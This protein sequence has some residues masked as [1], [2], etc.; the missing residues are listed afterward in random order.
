MTHFAVIDLG[1]NSVR[2]SVW[3]V[4]ADG[5]PVAETK[6][7]EMVRLSED[8]GD[9]MT[10]KEPAIARTIAALQKF[11]AIYSPLEDL[12][13]KAYAT[14]ATRQ[15]KNQKKFL[16]RVQD[17]VGLQIEVIPGVR[18]AELD[19]VGVINTLNVQSGLI[20]DTGGASTELVLVQNRQLEHRISIPFGSV[21]LTEHFVHHDPITPGDL[22]RLWSSVTNVFNGIWWLREAQNLPIIALGGSNRTLAKVQRRKHHFRNFEDIHGFRMLS[23]NV[24]RVFA[25][26]VDADVEARKAIPGLSRDR[27]DI[28]VAGLVPVVTMLR[29]IDADKIIFSQNGLR[30]GALYEYLQGTQRVAADE[31]VVD[32]TLTDFTVDD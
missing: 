24:N 7:K 14:A 29:F 28:I 8:M 21:N 22:F 4:K 23:R 27:A 11:K 25:E 19:Y 15:A 2:L 18:E 30:E 26:I 3:S 17:E 10:L 12:T 20:M 6:A 13:I 16:K 5:Q 32:E 31:N 1:S 9:E